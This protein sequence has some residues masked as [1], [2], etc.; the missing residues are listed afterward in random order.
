MSLE[1]NRELLLEM[2]R[3]M[4]LIRTFEERAIELF[5]EGK[6][7]GILHSYVGQ[8]AIAAGVCLNLTDSD[9]ITGTHRGHGHVLA[10][11]AD[12]K[13]VMA[14]LMGRVTGYNKGKGGSMHIACV[15]KGILGTNG[16]VGGGI[17]I[18]VGAA[19]THQYLGTGG[20]SVAFFGDGATNRGSFHECANLASLWLL[21]VI[22]V[23]E[24]NH[25]AISVSKE[26]STKLQD[27]SVRASSYAMPGVK[28]NG[29]DIFEV[30]TVSRVA[31]E[32]A[33]RGQG[34]TL[35]VFET[36]R[37]RGHEEGDTQPY[38]DKADIELALRND[39]IS[40]FVRKVVSEGLLSEEDLGR[41]RAAVESVVE[42]AVE[43][44]LSSPWPE[45]GVA[46]EDVFFV[47]GG[48][49]DA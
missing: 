28:A 32:R 34:P 31:V 14:E 49:G 25:F 41:I 3:R 10:K 18:A 42:E 6:I 12:P 36:H 5:K 37:Q 24:D 16:I 13:R 19:W 2:Y 15:E 43:F 1:F 9:Y 11:G 39:P 20:V 44:G 48:R 38:R 22:F 45:P 29:Q 47:G 26:R 21:P 7:P 46:L 40:M 17:G 33:R 8:E 4:Q 35:L 23:C 27:L 30:Y